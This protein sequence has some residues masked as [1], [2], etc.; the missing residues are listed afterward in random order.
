[1]KKCKAFSEL[2]WGE[3]CVDQRGGETE[4]TADDSGA[5]KIGYHVAL[6]DLSEVHKYWLGKFSLYVL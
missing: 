5:L 3:C 1:M 2:Q 6:L 4:H